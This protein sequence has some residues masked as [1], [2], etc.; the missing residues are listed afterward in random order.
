MNNQ[1][2]G[3]L[4]EKCHVKYHYKDSGKNHHQWMI[5]L[6]RKSRKWDIYMPTTPSLVRG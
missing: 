4:T 2:N 5:N 1:E 6:G 3:R